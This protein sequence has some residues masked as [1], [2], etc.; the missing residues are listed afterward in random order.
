MQSSVPVDGVSSAD[1]NRIAPIGPELVRVEALEP[2]QFLSATRIMPLG[3]SITEQFA[4][5]ESYRYYLW[6]SLQSSGFR[7]IDFVGSLRGVLGGA[8]ADANFD[9]DH[10]GHTGWRADELAAKTEEWA[11]TFRPDIV[12]LHVGTNDI[13][14]GQSVASTINELG[15]IIDCLRIGNPNVTILFSKIIPNQQNPSATAALNDAIPNLV[16]QKNRSESRVILVD[17]S[18][19]FD[20]N[21]DTFDG[22]HP[23]ESGE[24]KI[25]SRFFT[26]LQPLLS[27][28]APAP[29]PA[30]VPTHVPLTGTTFLNELNWSSA[31]N[32][33]GPVE[34]NRSVGEGLPN[35]GQTQSIRGR[36][37]GRGLGTHAGSRIDYRLDGKQKWFAAELGIDDETGGG[38]SVVYKVYADGKRIFSSAIIRGTDPVQL[39][40]LRIAGVRKLTLIVSDAGDGSTND[41]ANWANARVVS[42]VPSRLTI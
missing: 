24:R 6:N 42:Y 16:N 13:L 36:R 27:N 37:Y 41:H 32:G 23:N 10:E 35:D 22:L 19:G 17:Q 4:P 15:Q 38:G 3:D 33:L 7:D 28:P 29:V 21:R 18:A 14:Q 34:K 30:P 31:S 2:R 25:A 12:L 1:S 26:E 40:K 20:L 9:L 5:R 39:I 8:P 11:R